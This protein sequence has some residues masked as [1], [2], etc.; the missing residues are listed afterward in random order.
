MFKRILVPLDGSEV[1]ELVLP[2]VKELAEK[3]RCEVTLLQVIAPSQH[4][5]TVGGLDYV[6]FTDEQLELMRADARQYLEKVSR[7]DFIKRITS[8]NILLQ[9]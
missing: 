1:S 3:A 5:H 8:L 6:R 9:N 4:V 2:Y 7:K